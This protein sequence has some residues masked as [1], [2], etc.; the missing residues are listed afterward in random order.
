MNRRL[1]WQL[2]IRYLRGK[3]SINAVPIL[4]R[5]SMVAIAVGCAAM[6]IAFSV[7]NGLEMVVKDMYKAFYPDIRV[8]SVRGKFF[9]GEAVSLKKIAQINGVLQ[10]AAVL[11]DNALA[12]D[13]DNF[14]GST[15]RQ[16]VVTVKGIDND[17][18]K[19]NNVA[20]YI[21]TGVDTIVNSD[22]PTTLVGLHIGNELGT[23]VDNLF[24]R[25]ML[26][27]PNPDVTNP[28]ADPLNAYQSLKLH[29]SGTFIVGDEFDDKYMLAPLSKVQELFH[30]KGM[31]SSI[32]IKT[33]PSAE[34]EIRRQLQS[35]LG[36]SFKVETRYE[37]NQTLYSMMALEKW[38]MFVILLF[39]LIIASFN[40]VGALS[41]L[42]I[43]KQKDIAILR[44]MGA[45]PR[46]IRKIFLLEALL[47]SGTGG[48]IGLATGCLICVAQIRFSIIKIPGAFMV[49]A[50]PVRL[51]IIDVGLVLASI[52][53]IGV[54]A[55]WYP[56][57]KAAKFN[58]SGLKST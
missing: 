47:W 38:V 49:D 10:V 25:I 24:S 9:S 40:M 23:D 37:Q 31:Y 44:A 12:G 42:V 54:A 30:A 57:T 11:E 3:K 51:S 58:E 1:V 36:N 43:E 17:Y 32:E 14:S 39:V 18:F 4:S 53:V 35:M 48:L 5:V 19:V 16:K 29:P 2:A 22:N 50:F 34:N 6:I 20:E 7:F 8:S 41:M 56:A 21:N 13:L 15:N 27:Y 55:G 26:Y 28:E 33:D 46:D 52:I 45:M